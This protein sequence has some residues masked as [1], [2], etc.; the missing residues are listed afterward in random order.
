MRLGTAAVQVVAGATNLDVM[1]VVL[2]RSDP[3]ASDS[4]DTSE[5]TLVQVDASGASRAR[6]DARRHCDSFTQMDGFG[7]V[8]AQAWEQ[9]WWDPGFRL[10]RTLPRDGYWTPQ[11]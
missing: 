8:T 9:A 11:S 2:L 1:G 3:F 10:V 5:M 6:G 7:E 4:K